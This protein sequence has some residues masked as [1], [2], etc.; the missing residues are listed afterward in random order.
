MVERIEYHHRLQSS[1][2]FNI[3]NMRNDS[4]YN[5]PFTISP[6]LSSKFSTKYISKSS[7]VYILDKISINIYL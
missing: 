1:I 3:G 4:K 2:V 5:F 6:T 7:L